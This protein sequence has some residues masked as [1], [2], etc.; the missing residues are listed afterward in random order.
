MGRRAVWMGML[1]WAAGICLAET[2]GGYTWKLSKYATIS[3]D[4]LTVSV[5]KEAAREG[6]SARTTLDLRPYAGKCL[7]G[8]VVCEGTAISRPR[9][10]WNGLKFM[11]HYTDRNL[12]TPY[13]PNTQ[14]RLGSFPKQTITVR[15]NLEDVDAERAEVTLGLQ[16]S[17][18]TVVFDLSTLRF[19]K[20][21]PLFPKTNVAYTVTYSE[22]VAKVPQLRGVMLPAQPCT[23]D[24]FKTLRAWGATL[25]RYQMIRNWGAVNTDQDL[26]EYGR[27]LDGK[28]D[29]LEQVLV[30]A[31][32]YGIKIVVDLHVPPGGR[33][34]AKAM[35]MFHEKRFADC[36]LAC[37]RKIA[38]RF[39]GRPEIF[40]FDLINEPLQTEKAPFDYWNL[41]RMA[42]EA[43]RAID[44]VTP[45]ILESNEWDSAPAYRYLVP[46]EMENVI[47]QVHMYIPGEFTHQGVSYPRGEPFPRYRYPDPSRGW[48]REHLRRVLA[49]VRAFQERYKARIYVG[50]FSAIAWAEGAD[51]YI[52]DCIALFNEYGWDW[53]YHAFREWKG[54][55]VEHEGDSFDTLRPS[56]DNPRKRA[57]LEGF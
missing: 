24:D 37:W 49:P 15:C 23:E 30:W 34:T 3:G 43:V 21:D 19:T 2:G 7:V 45:I 29:H 13:W 41:Q 10:S 25:A 14:A 36:F 17:S 55:S 42:A 38:T 27:W 8:E 32:Q 50:E 48:D 4:R 16:D 31:K 1:A 5:P 22:R 40:G 20:E 52:R 57:L 11:L 6:G 39:K 47:Y 53:T 26:E 56:A 9:Q 18:G 28:L 12:G 44:P 35:N 33:N 54:W 46:L 51:A